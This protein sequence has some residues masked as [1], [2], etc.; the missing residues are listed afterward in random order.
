MAIS[1]YGANKYE[2]ML[3]SLIVQLHRMEPDEIDL[4]EVDYDSNMVL[5]VDIA[6][7]LSIGV[8][9]SICSLFYGF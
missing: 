8:T 1:Q 5:I 9:L 7:V 3:K 6:I 4:D 2:D